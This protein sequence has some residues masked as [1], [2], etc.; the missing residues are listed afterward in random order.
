MLGYPA[1]HPSGYAN[2]FLTDLCRNPEATD[3]VYLNTSM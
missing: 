2:L 3:G 1:Q